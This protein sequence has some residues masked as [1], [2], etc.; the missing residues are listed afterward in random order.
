MVIHGFSIFLH[1]KVKKY[2]KEIPNTVMIEMNSRNSFQNL[3]GLLEITKGTQKLFWGVS[4]LEYLQA[5]HQK[6]SQFVETFWN[7]VEEFLDSKTTLLAHNMA[8]WKTSHLF[9]SHSPQIFSFE[10]WKRLAYFFSGWI[11]LL[12]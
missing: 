6:S 7:G 8:H 10:H 11:Y 12:S 2:C 1:R 5:S 3:D 4:R 9:A